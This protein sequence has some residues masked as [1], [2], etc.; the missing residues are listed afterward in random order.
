V[1]AYLAK[2]QGPAQSYV[3]HLRDGSGPDLRIVPY[4]DLWRQRTLPG[5]TYVFTD[6]DRL[7]RRERKAA[8]S[9]CAA[10]HQDGVLNDPAKVLLRH[11]LL[12]RLH[13]EGA[14]RFRCFRSR[15]LPADL[16][17]PVFVRHESMHRGSSTPLLHSRV[18]VDHWLARLTLRALI[19]NLDPAGLLV[20]EFLD[21]ADQDGVFRKYSAF[22]VGTRILPRHLLFSRAWEVKKPD[23]VGKAF[24]REERDF[25]DVNPH[26]AWLDE[27]FRL[28]GIDYGRIDYSLYHGEPQVWEVNLNPVVLPVGAMEL[29]NVR[30]DLHRRFA[31][32][33]TS[34]LE[35]LDGE[36]VG[37]PVVPN[38]ASGVRRH[39]VTT[40]GRR[41]VRRVMRRPLPA[42]AAHVLWQRLPTPVVTGL[43]RVVRRSFVW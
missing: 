7:D 42:R 34:A 23:L 15:Q 10:V 35:S 19:H 3:D 26:A 25:V 13:H 29:E 33:F 8:H 5:G 27:V 11:D 20:V 38:P 28:A 24:L 9:V 31:S 30:R 21:T 39:I 14:N 12:E 37:P 17:F 36:V 22:R 4:P 2:V 43:G 6:L 18:A 40:G 41:A 1:I 16:R 32:T